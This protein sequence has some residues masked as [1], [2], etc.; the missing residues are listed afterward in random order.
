M[1]IDFKQA[2]NTNHYSLNNR[3]N[4]VLYQTISRKAKTGKTQILLHLF[5][6]YNLSLKIDRSGKTSSKRFRFLHKRIFLTM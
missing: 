1:T 3:I 4:P 6:I 5:S 2:T